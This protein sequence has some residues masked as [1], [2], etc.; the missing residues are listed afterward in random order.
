M[1]EMIPDSPDSQGIST[2]PATTGAAL[3]RLRNER[4]RLIERCVRLEVALRDAI[5]KTTRVRRRTIE[6]EPRGQRLRRGL[7]RSGP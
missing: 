2:D 7:D 3:A 4:D 6:V 5:R 1:T